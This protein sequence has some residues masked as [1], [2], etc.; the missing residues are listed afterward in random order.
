[1]ETHV[2]SYK[3]IRRLPRLFKQVA[4]LQKAVFKNAEND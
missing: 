4:E 3:A 1:M 2:E